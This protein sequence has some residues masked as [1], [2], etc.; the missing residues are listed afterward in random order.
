LGRH[1]VQINNAGFDK[2]AQFEQ[3][4]PSQAQQRQPGGQAGL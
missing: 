1:P 4:M 2:P 3:M